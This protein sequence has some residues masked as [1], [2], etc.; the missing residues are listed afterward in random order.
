[1]LDN[2]IFIISVVISYRMD[3]FYKV[4]IVNKFCWCT[5]GY[6][7]ETVKEIKAK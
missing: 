2:D 5:Y 7:K 6:L 4:S 1:M 3:G